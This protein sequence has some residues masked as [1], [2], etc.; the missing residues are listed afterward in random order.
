MGLFGKRRVNVETTDGKKKVAIYNEENGEIK[1]A[2]GKVKP[3]DVK[4]II[5]YGKTKK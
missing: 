2:K 5:D 1:T 4:N 3:K